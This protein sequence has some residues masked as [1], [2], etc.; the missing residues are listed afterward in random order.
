[1]AGGQVRIVD[2]SNFPAAT[3]IAAALVEVDPGGLRELH[4][5]PNT[6]EWQY[7]I[8]GRG[9][10]TVFASGG[11]ARTFDYQAGDVGYIPFA[12]GHYIENTG[13]EPLRFLEMFRSDHFADLSLNQWMALTPPELVKAHLNIDDQTLAALSRDKP[14]VVR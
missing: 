5:H 6:D 13:D 14:V 1:V 8:S 12:M 4:W 2:S 11:K 7:Y 10:M 9:R 3:T